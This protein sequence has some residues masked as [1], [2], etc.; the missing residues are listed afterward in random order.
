MK[1][2][3]SKFKNTSV[4][5]EL[6]IKQITHEILTNSKS[7]I[8]EKI[9]KEFFNSKKELSKELKLYNMIVKEKYTNLDDAKLFLEEAVSERKK[10]DEIKLKKEKYNLIKKIKESY[11][12]DK[13]LS[14]S[15]TNYKL[16]ASIYKV[17]ESKVNGRQIEIRDF[18]TSNNTILEHVTS[19]KINI[20]NSS[21]DEIYETLKRQSEDLRLLTY[22]V[23]IDNFNSK[24]NN[25]N[26]SQKNLLKEYINNVS[27]TSTFPNFIKEEVSKIV[28]SIKKESD[29]I[30]DKVTKIKITETIK[31]IASPSFL[32]E[33]HDK[34]V[35][36]LM[37]SYELLKELK[38][39]RTK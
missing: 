28:S 18:I 34:Q 23:L 22:K 1:V 24:Y 7:P 21:K 19:N 30:S 14:S 27:N 8:S 36:T 37:L 4:L 33:T 32:K 35:S 2:K 39:V 10:L 11:E 20:S 9:V 38:D 17:F 16:L 6:L 25:L 31:I 13:F 26:E 3:H 29:I 12:I 5:F 15:I